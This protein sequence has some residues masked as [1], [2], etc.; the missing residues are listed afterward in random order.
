MFCRRRQHAVEQAQALKHAVTGRKLGLIILQSPACLWF[1]R[2]KIQHYTIDCTI[3]QQE[4][5]V[6]LSY[7]LDKAAM[8]QQGVLLRIKR[9]RDH[10]APEQIGIYMRSIC[11]GVLLAAH[12]QHDCSSR[13]TLLLHCS[14]GSHQQNISPL[15][16]LS[17]IFGHIWRRGGYCSSSRHRR[18]TKE[19]M[20]LR[21]AEAGCAGKQSP[22]L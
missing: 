17:A 13:L 4:Q 7:G 3:K 6:Y 1:T 16:G 14:F 22:G 15:D 5:T 18:A 21:A 10:Q 11:F 20:S 12:V 8:Q 9:R 2:H 19:A